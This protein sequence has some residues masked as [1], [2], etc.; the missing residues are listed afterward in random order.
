VSKREADCLISGSPAYAARPPPVFPTPANI[1][2]CSRI[3][4]APDRSGAGGRQPIV[5][6]GGYLVLPRGRRSV[7]PF[8]HT[9]SALPAQPSGSF[10][11]SAWALASEALAARAGLVVG[12]AVTPASPTPSLPVA[13]MASADPNGVTMGFAK[14]YAGAG[15]VTIVLRIGPS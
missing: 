1:R 11:T 7:D 15:R 5:S 14:A 10:S 4:C 8:R 3:G 12:R 9:R 13:I 6:P 2:A